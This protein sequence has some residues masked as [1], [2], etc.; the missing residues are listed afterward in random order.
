MYRKSFFLLLLFFIVNTSILYSH[1]IV[2][3]RHTDRTF[4]LYTW[5]SPEALKMNVPVH[6]T[7]VCPEEDLISGAGF[8]YIAEKKNIGPFFHFPGHTRLK[9]GNKHRRHPILDFNIPLQAFYAFGL[10]RQDL[11]PPSAILYLKHKEAFAWED[12]LEHLYD[13]GIENAYLHGLITTKNMWGYYLQENYFDLL[14][15]TGRPHYASF[16][17][18]RAT[19]KV[20]GYYINCRDMLEDIHQH[21]RFRRRRALSECLVFE[22][23]QF[24][25]DVPTLNNIEQMTDFYNLLGPVQMGFT[26]EFPPDWQLLRGV[27]FIYALD[28]HK[29]MP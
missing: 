9:S 11:S 6:F 2:N 12:V 10:S 27:L 3:I 17:K 19:V 24:I 14:K 8:G 13:M 29:H 20:Q 23:S 16:Y 25:K 1:E 26:A 18:D 21:E 22:T 15:G 7:S 5:G 28:G 4:T